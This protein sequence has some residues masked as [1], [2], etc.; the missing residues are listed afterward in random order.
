[1]TLRALADPAPADWWVR[2]GTDEWTKIVLGP[3][4][5]AAYARLQL[6]PADDESDVDLG[7]LTVTALRRVLEPHTS[8]PD[9]CF[10]GQWGGQRVGSSSAP[11]P[12]DLS[13]PSPGSRRPR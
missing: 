10:F 8:T 11:R 4:G 5:Y 7:H 9:D 2:A 6:V 1:M 13:E 3:P 12:L